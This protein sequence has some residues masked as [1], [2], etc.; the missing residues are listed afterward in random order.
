MSSVAAVADVSGILKIPS[1]PA[2]ARILF[3]LHF[4]FNLFLDNLP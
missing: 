2:D 1:F 4:N 3:T